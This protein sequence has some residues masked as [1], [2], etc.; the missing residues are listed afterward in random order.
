MWKRV[1]LLMQY[2]CVPYIMR[3]QNKNDTPW[4]RSEF[5]GIYITMARWCNQPSF[6]KKMS[7]RQYCLANQERVKTDGKVCASMRALNDFEERYPEIAAKYFDL[8]F[9]EYYLQ[10]QDEPRKCNEK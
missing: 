2:R 9:D 4:K 6:Y 10:V 3:Y 7:F 1:A 5:R 8:R